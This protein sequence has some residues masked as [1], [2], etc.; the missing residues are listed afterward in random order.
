MRFDF[1]AFGFSEYMFFFTRGQIVTQECKFNLNDYFI[2]FYVILDMFV[3]IA[4]TNGI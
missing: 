4:R 3:Q 1:A 2:L